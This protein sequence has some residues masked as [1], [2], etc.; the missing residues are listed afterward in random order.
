M[1]IFNSSGSNIYLS[2]THCLL[3]SIVRIPHLFLSSFL[4]LVHWLIHKRIW[5]KPSVKN[6]VESIFGSPSILYLPHHSQIYRFTLDWIASNLQLAVMIFIWIHMAFL[7]GCLPLHWIYQAINVY[8]WKANSCEMC[9]PKC[10]EIH[11]S[12]NVGTHCWKTHKMPSV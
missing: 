11:N 8:N 9:K 5:L 2:G 3:P 1:N 4:F 7:P 6:F 10:L 12:N